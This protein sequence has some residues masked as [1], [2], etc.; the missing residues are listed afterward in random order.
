MISLPALGM[1]HHIVGNQSMVLADSTEVVYTYGDKSVLQEIASGDN[2][3]LQFLG[4]SHV[5]PDSSW[6]LSTLGTG[7]LGALRLAGG[8]SGSGSGGDT[9]IFTILDSIS[10]G[11]IFDTSAY[12]IEVY[13]KDG[14]I[15]KTTISFKDAGSFTIKVNEAYTGNI[16]I[17]LKD[18]GTGADYLDEGTG[19]NKDLRVIASSNGGDMTVNLNMLTEIATRQLFQ[20]S[21]NV[22][23]DLS[24]F[25]SAQI[26]ATNGNIATAFGL[27]GD[28]D[29]ITEKSDRIQVMKD[30]GTGYTHSK[31][32][33]LSE[34]DIEKGWKNVAL[35]ALTTGDNK[36][37]KDYNFKVRIIDQA[38][39]QSALSD[40]YLITFDG[41]VEEL[42]LN[43][44]EDTGANSAD[45]IT[46]NETTIIGNIEKGA[47]VEYILDGGDGCITLTSAVVYDSDDKA[48]IH[49]PDGDLDFV[50]IFEDNSD[51]VKESQIT[52]TFDEDIVKPATFD[53]N[54]F[55]ITINGTNQTIGR[56][57]TNGKKVLIYIS[58]NVISASA[59]ISVAYN[60][61]DNVKA[62]AGNSISGIASKAYSVNNTPP[63]QPTISSIFDDK[64]DV[65]GEVGNNVLTDDNVL[66]IIVDIS[67]ASAI[68][69]GGLFFYN[70]GEKLANSFTLDSQDIAKGSKTVTLSLDNSADRKAYELGVK[71][72]DKSDNVSVMSD[73]KNFSVDA[74]V[75]APTIKLIDKSLPTSDHT[76]SI[77]T[78]KV[79]NIETSAIWEYSLNS[80]EDW[81]ADNNGNSS[82]T[83]YSFSLTANT[84]YEAQDIKIRQTDKAGNKA[85]L[86]INYKVIVDSIAPEYQ[87]TEGSGNTIILIFSEDLSSI[88]ATTSTATGAFTV[89]GNTVTKVKTD[90]NKAYLSI[91]N[92]VDDASAIAIDISY[93]RPSSD[94]YHLKDKAGNLVNNLKI[95]TKDADTPLAGISSNDTF[96]GGLGDDTLTGNDGVDTF[97]LI[98]TL[99][100]TAMIPS[101]ILS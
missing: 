17:R 52:L 7:T 59:E 46:S 28:N 2:A 71:I 42:T 79:S 24:D 20:D 19:Q 86:S 83:K 4:Q 41:N 33:R 67:G 69:G 14:E 61:S 12:T 49:K 23:T 39:N 55:A 62:L 53:N 65:T 11:Q 8:G 60:Q 9:T 95:G 94:S 15:L 31:Y 98:T 36:A 78:V 84:A 93:T 48:A 81:T 38:G 3:L 50:R 88:N 37:N 40:A 68:A 27:N 32:V 97:L 51:T 101:L 13:G 75:N 72:I 96:I 92:T 43:L 22:D 18:A 87:S 10:T 90:G 57:E 76:T 74:T 30:N 1:L 73:L 16:L 45:G 5:S 44:K 80:G 25:T 58:G 34:A 100:P 85:I 91:Q 82:D 64:G 29:I 89:E 54:S 70:K 77:A 21:S 66:S 99:Q 63:S 35:S 6:S 26:S 47:K 56:V